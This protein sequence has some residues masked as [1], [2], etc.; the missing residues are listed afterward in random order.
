MRRSEEIGGDAEE[1]RRRL[2]VPRTCIMLK[3]HQPSVMPNV[4]W[5]KACGYRAPGAWV[6]GDSVHGDRVRDDSGY[7]EDRAKNKCAECMAC[8]PGCTSPR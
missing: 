7:G 4:I 8:A 5:M 1:M 6:Q 2:S 3:S